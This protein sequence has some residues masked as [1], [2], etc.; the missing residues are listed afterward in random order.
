MERPLGDQDEIPR[1][2]KTGE[3]IGT[4]GSNNVPV[5]SAELYLIVRQLLVVKVGLIRK[6]EGVGLK[7]ELS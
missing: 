3:R 2:E 7:I 1:I 6:A 4:T 5:P